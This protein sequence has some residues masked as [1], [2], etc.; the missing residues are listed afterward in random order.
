LFQ[1]QYEWLVV[2]KVKLG[3]NF[4]AKDLEFRILSEYL[5]LL[6]DFKP[7]IGDILPSP[8]TYD[9]PIDLKNITNFSYYPL[10]ALSIVQLQALN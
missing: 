7:Q 1:K 2:F 10:Y 4:E 6:E 9:H 5:R 3:L 8:D